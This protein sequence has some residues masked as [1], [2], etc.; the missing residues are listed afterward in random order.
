MN[1]KTKPEEKKRRRGRPPKAD[2]PDTRGR[3][4]KAALELFAREGYSGASIRKIAR[5]VGVTEGAIYAHF[6]GKRTIYE[7]LVAQAGPPVIL[8]ELAT[9]NLPA[10][11]EP[12]SFVRLLARRVVEEWDKPRARLFASVFMRESGASSSVG[13]TSILGAVEEV[14]RRLGSVFRRWEEEGLIETRSSPEHLV[15]EL[16]APIVYIRFVYLHGQ[17]TEEERR[18]GLRLAERHVDHFV[19][20]VLRKPGGEKP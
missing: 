8:E 16:F 15:W 12:E 20:Y 9:G 11:A 7:A 14:Q 1:K 2:A 5:E 3:I 4:L 17:A 10:S 18:A 19:S 13:G 6:E